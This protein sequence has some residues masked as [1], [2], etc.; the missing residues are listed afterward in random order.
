MSREGFVEKTRDEIRSSLGILHTKRTLVGNEFFRGVSGGERKRVSLA[1]VMAGQVSIRHRKSFI[2]QQV[3]L[4]LTKAVYRVL[5]NVGTN[6]AEGLTPVPRSILPKVCAALPMNSGRRSSPL[7]IKQETL[8]TINLTRLWWLQL[9]GQSTMARV[10]WRVLT[11]RRWDLCMAVVR[12]M[13]IYLFWCL[14]LIDMH[15]L[16][17]RMVHTTI[18]TQTAVRTT[19]AAMVMPCTPLHLP[20]LSATRSL[21]TMGNELVTN[22]PRKEW[23]I[24]FWRVCADLPGIGTFQTEVT[25]NWPGLAWRATTWYETQERKAKNDQNIYIFALG[26]RWTNFLV[27]HW[28]PSFVT[29]N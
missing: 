19:T 16:Q 7:F 4:K 13:F 14:H 25:E 9:G 5:C 18:Q 1:E 17:I 12:L 2:N 23:T 22:M 6:Q 3:S 26:L 29:C 11:S 27:L 8:S 21:T 10:I 28:S 15:F 24:L 20:R